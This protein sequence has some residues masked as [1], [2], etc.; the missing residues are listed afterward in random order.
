MSI[1]VIGIITLLMGVLSFVFGLTFAIQTFIVSTLFG[2]SAAVIITAMSNANVQPAHLLLL[3][4]AVFV[5]LRPELRRNAMDCLYFPNAGFWLLLTVVYGISSAALMPRLFAGVTD[6][7]AVRSEGGPM[8]VPLAPTS[9]NLTQTAYFITDFL[10][11]IGVYSCASTKDGQRSVARGLLLCAAINLLFA[12]I[13]LLTYWT[14]TGDALA[15]IRNASYRLLNDTEISGYKRIVGSFSEAASFAYITLGMLAFSGRLWLSGTYSKV[16]FPLMVLSLVALMFSTS[17]TAY[18][19]LGAFL[20]LIYID[21]VAR[22]LTRAVSVETF[23]FACILPIVLL[24]FFIA[25]GLNDAQW[26]Y[27]EGLFKEMVLNK[28][29]SNSG[30]ERTA[31]NERALR[32]FVD[33]DGFGAGIGSLR[34]SSFPIA[35]LASVGVIGAATYGLF[36]VY[37]LWRP[38]RRRRSGEETETIWNLAAKWACVALLIAASIAGSFPDLGLIFFVFAALASARCHRHATKVHMA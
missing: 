12:A 34:A 30:V 23:C 7:F 36:L 27:F 28:L 37:V 10:C 8:L 1:E 24:I 33:T 32:V 35:V 11:F 4:F 6:V 25:L 15:F 38:G 16:T 3:F 9:G 22:T 2:A 19:G 31:W 29:S 13:D 21:S 26:L 5:A 14:G 17:T 20:T 18:V